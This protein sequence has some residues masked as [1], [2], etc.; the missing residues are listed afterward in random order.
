MQTLRP[1]NLPG[2]ARIRA[3]RNLA[4]TKV[5]TSLDQTLNHRADDDGDP[6]GAARNDRRFAEAY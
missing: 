6:A 1:A 4:A 5:F 3:R 2:E